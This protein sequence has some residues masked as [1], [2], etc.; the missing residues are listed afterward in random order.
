MIR[1]IKGDLLKVDTGI[2]C[3]QVN[4]DGVMGAGVAWSICT[5]VLTPEQYKQYKVYC[6][7]KGAKAIGTVHYSELIPGKKYV[8][9]AFSQ[10]RFDSSE[11]CITNYAAV[12]KCLHSVREFAEKNRLSV[13]LPGYYGCG[14]AGGNWEVV[15][16]IILRTFA[17]SKVDCTIV[18]YDKEN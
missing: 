11:G 13:A 8:A 2:I 18:Y 16:D 1:E 15:H 12:K 3:H 14:I 9:N 5:K 17:E 6:A 4:F 10:N 7:L